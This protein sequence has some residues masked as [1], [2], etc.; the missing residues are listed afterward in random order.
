M[1]DDVWTD[2]MSQEIQHLGDQPLQG[3]KFDL[4]LLPSRKR[5]QSCGQRGTA[6]GTLDGSIQ[7]PG[8]PW[9]FRNRFFQQAQA[10]QYDGQ[11]V[12][13]VV[14]HPARQLPDALHLL[15]FMKLPQCDLALACPLL[16][17]AFQFIVTSLQGVACIAQGGIG[18]RPFRNVAPDC[19]DEIA[20]ISPPVTQRNIEVAEFSILISTDE[21][22]RGIA[23]LVYR[24]ACQRGKQLIVRL[25]QNIER[26]DRKSV[27]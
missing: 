9:I 6:F 23:F 26:L 20:L 16:D 14:R 21:R 5:Q 2:G 19:R 4:Q 1:N 13:E 11:Q 18:R 8:Y 3:N 10:A 15:G 24:T 27:V 25:Q 7:Q 22:Y 17:A 12:V